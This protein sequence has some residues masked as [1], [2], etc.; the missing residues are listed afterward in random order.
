MGLNRVVLGRFSVN[1]K[2]WFL[3]LFME[4]IFLWFNFENELFLFDD[5]VRKEVRLWRDII[6]IW[7][8]C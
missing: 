3:F 8:D 1:F 7:F 2:E 6:L 4:L 5:E